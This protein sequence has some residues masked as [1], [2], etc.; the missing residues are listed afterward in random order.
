MTPAV[1]GTLPTG[2]VA[3]AAVSDESPS[4]R[5]LYLLLTTNDHAFDRISLA[6]NTVDQQSTLD[7]AK[8]SIL[9]FVGIPA[10]SGAASVSAINP[11]QTVAPGVS[12]VLVGQV[13]DSVG[14]PVMGANASFTAA[15]PGI[16]IANPTVTTTAGGWAQT[17]VTA[18]ATA[19]IYNVTLSS[20]NLSANFSIN[21]NAAGSGGSTGA[22]G[23]PTMSIYAGDGELLMQN[24]ST[25]ST[26]THVPLT[27]Q[28]LDENGNPL[29]N[30]PVTFTIETG[31]IGF[32]IPRNQGLTDQNGFARGDYTSAPLPGNSTNLLTKVQATSTYGSVEFYEV[33]HDATLNERQPNS[34]LLTPATT[35][36]ITVQQGVVS[37]GAIAVQTYNEKSP[38]P[39]PNVGLRLAD[40]NS[41][42]DLSPV[43]SCQGLSRGDNNGVS[44]CDVLAACQ[45]A[46]FLPHDYGVFLYA[47][48]Q[49]GFSPDNPSDPRQRIGPARGFPR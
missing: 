22:S 37:A 7:P 4:S 48:E 2:N 29:P 49:Q 24:E 14:R 10:Q 31:G 44:R 46:T 16:A 15:T 20:G 21:V 6:T 33:T 17:V 45:I 3:A 38:G 25:N 34:L 43:A 36:T 47:G 41:R 26:D 42:S 18:P 13:L 1:I 30:V 27:V 11:S 12:V 35:R 39:I 23:V 9:P 28:I 8:G 32:I 5:Y 19:G 40:P